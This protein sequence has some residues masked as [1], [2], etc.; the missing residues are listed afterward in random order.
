M[1]KTVAIVLAA[2]KSERLGGELPKPF[3]S[4]HGRELYQYSLQMFD[5]H[6]Q[7]DS[8]ILVVPQQFLSTEKAKNK[9]DKINLIVGGKTRFESVKNALDHLEKSVENV[10]IHDAARPFITKKLIDNCLKNLLKNKALSCAIESTD[11]L[12]VKDAK[13]NADS[14]PDRSKTMRIQTPQ[15]FRLDLLKKAYSLAIK[16]SKT[17][18]TD[19]GSLIH[20]YGLAP[21]SLVPG[22][23][24]NIKITYASDL[25]L[26]ELILNEL[27]PIASVREMKK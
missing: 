20:Y 16:E 24:Q 25:L 14:Y 4:I 17:D 9:S 23:E 19:D 7:I 12:V 21:L 1:N 27:I 6:P 13:G 2:G 5:Q 26:A 10:I 11:T 3:L 8:I 22:S 15:A 18:F